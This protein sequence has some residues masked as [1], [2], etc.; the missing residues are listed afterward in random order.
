ML[1]Y[2]ATIAKLAAFV[3]C[4]TAWIATH[5]LALLAMA[6]PFLLF[7]GRWTV[8]AFAL[9]LLTWLCRWSFTGHITVRT[10]LNLPIIFL[11]F[12]A[13][14][15]TAI[16]IDPAMSR[17]KQWGLVLQ[18]AIFF[19]LVNSL[20]GYRSIRA[21]AVLLVVATAAVALVG[22]AGTDWDAVRLVDLPWLYGHLPRLDL[23]LPGSGVPRASTLFHPREVGATLAWLLP[24]P[25]A[26]LLFAHDGRLRLLS[27]VALVVGG[28]VLLLTQSLPALLGLGLALL[29]IAVWRNRWAVLSIP[30]GL[31]SLLALMWAYGP[32]RAGLTLL[33]LDRPL[34]AGVLL[35]LDIWSRAWAMIR[36]MPYTGVGLNTFPLVQTHFYPGMLL[37]PE[38]HAHNLALQT[39][40]DLGVP[41]LLALLWLAVAFFLMVVRAY[42]AT[43]NGDLRVLLVGL[44]AGFV[45]YLGNGLLDAVT[46]GAKPVA[47]LFGMLALAAAIAML[48]SRPPLEPR[49]GSPNLSPL[50]FR[51]HGL[52]RALP[53]ALPVGLLALG[54]VVSPASAALNLG[55]IRAHRLLFQ[56]RQVGSLPTAGV[57]AAIGPL[58]YA[59]RR[60]PVGSRPNELLGSL[61]AWQGDEEAALD[62]LEQAVAADGLATITRYAPW[63]H[64]KNRLEGS[65]SPDIWQALIQ[66]YSQWM[67]RYPERAETYV[68]LAVVYDTYLGQAAQARAVLLAGQGVAANPA[69]L[70][71]YYLSC[72]R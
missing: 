37:G 70:L 38:P 46:L 3:K 55:A 5:E 21:G 67:V 29:L 44:A 24:L 36:D 45:A 22:L 72:L 43:A 17:A 16:S 11:L 65:P 60:N 35:R 53:V 26:L 8:A 18:A 64:W 1:G 33:S 32:S 47:S 62:A 52:W 27:G 2:K 19:G 10:A 14:V 48:E 58:D 56:A 4:G 20:K 54:L 50:P 13:L 40:V 23:G 6:A 51:G 12:M 31:L 66:V 71:S 7:P 25:L 61:Y 49:L 28:A 59:A 69:A 30:L 63:L 15:G 68:R 41:G 34:G 42:H 57:P 9:V 39:A